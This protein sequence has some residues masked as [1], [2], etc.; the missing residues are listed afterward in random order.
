MRGNKQPHPPHFLCLF[1]SVHT[2]FTRV[3][4]NSPSLPLAAQD[5]IVLLSPI[6]GTNLDER[7]SVDGEDLGLGALWRLLG[8]NCH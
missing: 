1:P 8:D 3:T 5:L 2:R 6:P 4:F 7:L